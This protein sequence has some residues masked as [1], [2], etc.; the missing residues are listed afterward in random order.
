[1]TKLKLLSWNVNSLRIRG[2]QLPALLAQA[3]IHQGGDF[4]LGTAEHQQHGKDHH[5]AED[6]RKQ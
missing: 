4:D 6:Q 1:M 5:N 3:A 2:D